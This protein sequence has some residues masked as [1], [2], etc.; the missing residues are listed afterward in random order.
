MIYYCGVGSRKTPPIVCSAMTHIAL[1]LQEKGYILRSGG[2]DGADTAFENGAGN[3]KEIFVPWDG[4]N[5][6]KLSK[7]CHLYT[8]EATEI[9]M[10][11]VSHWDFLTKPSKKLHTRNVHQV[12]GLDL[13]T[14]V[15]FLICW[16][17]NGKLNGGTATAIKIAQFHGIR[18]I[19]LFEE[20]GNGNIQRKEKRLAL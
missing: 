1:Q 13:K 12:L 7:N 17:E 9:A 15:K 16:T 19:N 2:A 5:G 3:L 14:P 8:E 10:K 4:F 11:F 18:V 6:R 20:F